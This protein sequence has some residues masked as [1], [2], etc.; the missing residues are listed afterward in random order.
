[1]PC[2][3][4]KGDGG[5]EVDEGVMSDGCYSALDGV[6]VAVCIAAGFDESVG[7]R[8]H[9]RGT[10]P[11]NGHSMEGGEVVHHQSNS[12]LVYIGEGFLFFLFWGGEG[13]PNFIL[14]VCHES[15]TI[16]ENVQSRVDRMH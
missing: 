12:I 5:I 1:M 4:P 2:R 10:M 9:A 3:A 14:S 11:W 15:C 13:G 16:E 6:C 7:R 8:T